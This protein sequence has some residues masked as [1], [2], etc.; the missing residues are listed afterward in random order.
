MAMPKQTQFTV[1]YW[2]VAAMLIFYQLDGKR[3]EFEG[4]IHP[5]SGLR[6]GR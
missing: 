5:L 4:A 2:I 3:V 1:W 6:Q